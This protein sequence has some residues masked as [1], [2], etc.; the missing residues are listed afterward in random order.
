[1]TVFMRKG[2]P[3]ESNKMNHG[4]AGKRA[5]GRG[6]GRFYPTREEV[7]TGNTR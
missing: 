4:Q 1:M 3:E 6:G 2:L 5:G 7:M